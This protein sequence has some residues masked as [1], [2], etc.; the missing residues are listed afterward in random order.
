MATETV[1]ITVTGVIS[2]L[3]L[4]DRMVVLKEKDTNKQFVLV[5][6]S[7]NLDTALKHYYDKQKE[8]ELICDRTTFGTI[9]FPLIVKRILKNTN[10]FLFPSRFN[11]AK[12]ANGQ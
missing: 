11:R 7:A 10:D 5:V 4:D 1:R 12:N 9:K 2:Y 8:V 6:P 3:D